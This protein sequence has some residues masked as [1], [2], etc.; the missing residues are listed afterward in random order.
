VL[1]GPQGTIVGQNATGGA[2]FVNTND[3]IIGGGVHGYLN[4]RTTAITTISAPRARSTCRS[5]TRL[6]P[7]R[8]LRPAPRYGFYNITGPG[9]APYTFDKGNQRMYAGRISLLWKPTDRLTILSKTDFDHLDMGA[10]PATPF[11]NYSTLPR[12]QHAQPELY[13]TCSTSF[14]TP[15]AARD[16]FFRSTLQG[17]LRV[18]RRDQV[19]LGQRLFKGNTMYR[20]IWTAPRPTSAPSTTASTRQQITQEFNLISPDNARFT[21]LLG[22]VRRCGTNII[23][24]RR[25]TS[26]SSACRTCSGP[27]P[28]T[29][30]RAPIRNARSRCSVKPAMRSRPA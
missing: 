17:R 18:R 12:H 1:R 10:Y 27:P 15:Q 8:A 14:N 29:I 4:H 16:K 7:R 22:G 9:G 24:A 20:P 25:R 2:V 13:A 30:F 3:P 11:M 26:C 6:P 19:P 28:I 5:A 23:S 21:W